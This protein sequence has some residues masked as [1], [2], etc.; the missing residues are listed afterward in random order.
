MSKELRIGL[1]DGIPIAV[2]YFG[3]SFTFGILAAKA[4]IPPTIA[5]LISLTNMT[6]AGQFAGLELI[7]AGSSYIEMILTQ[8]VI[9]LRYS[10]MSLSLTQKTSSEFTTPKR[11]GLSAV[12]TDEVF[13][14][15]S[16]RSQEITPAYLA[17]LQILPVIG[18]TGGTFVG[19]VAGSILPTAVLSA[20]GLALYGMFVAIVIPPARE[21]THIAAVAV[22]ALV[23]SCVLYY[24]PLFSF[25]SSGFSIIIC[26]IIAAGIGAILFPIEETEETV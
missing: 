5:A 2:G 18:W 4:D 11:L 25:I 17:G 8:L 9:N 26:T 19:A 7:I 21:N 6:S 20:L 3:V 13:A 22:I 24:A 14:V 10:L 15:A 12:I 16:S 23:I 1:K